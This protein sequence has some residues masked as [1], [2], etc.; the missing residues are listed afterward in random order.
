VQ[1]SSILNYQFKMPDGDPLIQDPITKNQKHKLLIVLSLFLVDDGCTDGTADAVREVWP[2]ATII[3][4]NGQLYWCGGM[5]V[6][7]AEARKSDPDYY[8][9][10][11]DDT[12]I[13]PDALSELL[14]IISSPEHAAIAVAPIADP[15][16]G[17]LIYGG[18]MGHNVQPIL[19]SGSTHIC[20]TM[21]ANCALVPRSVFQRIGSFHHIYTHA[22]GDFDYGFL[23]TRN[24]IPIIQAKKVLGTSEPNCPENTW[25]DRNLPRRTRFRLLWRDPKG[26]PFLEWLTYTRRNTGW[27]WP[28]RCISPALRILCGR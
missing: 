20:D 13:L 10:L 22:M 27:R 14:A 19:P 2:E 12:I 3:H 28:Y 11:N 8:L 24:G 17:K 21:N 15:V 25:L 1:A 23:A 4:G 5:R 26:L 16:T 6:A 9:L 7:W 18:R